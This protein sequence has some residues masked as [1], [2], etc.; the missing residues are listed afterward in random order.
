MWSVHGPLTFSELVANGLELA[1]DTSAGVGR[2]WRDWR[3]TMSHNEVQKALETRRGSAELI[4]RVAGG[5]VM[6]ERQLQW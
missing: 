2:L 5:A 1:G 6:F 4:Q 3:T